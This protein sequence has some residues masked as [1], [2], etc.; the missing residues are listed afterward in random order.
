[1]VTHGGRVDLADEALARVRAPTLVLVQG[2]DSFVREL[3]EWTL[4]QVSA[5]TALEAV[6]GAEQLLH[7]PE[8]WRRVGVQAAEWFDRHL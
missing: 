1:V 3:A 7:R 5:P 2:S 6:A 4:A 8:E